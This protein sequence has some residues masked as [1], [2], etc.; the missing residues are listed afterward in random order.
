[1]TGRVAAVALIALGTAALCSGCGSSAPPGPSHAQFTAAA[2]RVCRDG[3]AAGR[4]A[5]PVDGSPIEQ[6]QALSAAIGRIGHALTRVT[7]PDADV[8]ALARVVAAYARFADGER[9]AARALTTQDRAT[10][11]R[12]IGEI[13]AAE[14]VLRRDTVALGIA[15]CAPKQATTN[16]AFA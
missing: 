3:M 2:N 6:T 5:I 8:G 11:H 16:G 14:T 9:L 15:D 7:P 12:A 1:M 13:S 4:A 10:L